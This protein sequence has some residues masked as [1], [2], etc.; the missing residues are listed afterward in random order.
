MEE[1][2]TLVLP[3]DAAT[4]KVARQAVAERFTQPAPHG[5]GKVVWFDFD[6]AAA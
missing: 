1:G 2:F 6:L 5:N 3:S 4:P